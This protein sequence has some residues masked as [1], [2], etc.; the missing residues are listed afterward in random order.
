[1]TQVVEIEKTKPSFQMPEQTR[2]E[3]DQN[4][5]D[6]RNQ[7]IIDAIELKYKHHLITECPLHGD[8]SVDELSTIIHRE[9]RI[10]VSERY[11]GVKVSGRKN[12]KRTFNV[13]LT[14]KEYNISSRKI[15]Q[16]K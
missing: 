8:C 1:M 6:K 14:H 16:L 12:Y 11:Y 4:D 7:G 15:L 13:V 5:L 10:F 9:F 2:A 3:R